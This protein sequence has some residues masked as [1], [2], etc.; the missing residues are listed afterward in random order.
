MHFAAIAGFLAAVFPMVATPGASLTLLTQRV[1][2]GGPRQ[3]LLVILGTATGLYVHMTLAAL[4]LSGLVMHSSQAFAAVRLAGAVYLVAL[5]IWTWRS[6][7]VRPAARQAL[8]SLPW[9]GHSTYV[10]ALLG[11]VLN[12]K[13]ASIYLTLIPQ[14]LDL[15]DPVFI[16]I[17]IL[18]TGHAL[19][20]TLWLL[21]WTA[22]IARAAH[23][24]R[25]PSFKAVLSRITG[26]VLIALG[27]RAAMR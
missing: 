10:Q 25:S 14:F 18:A 1:S 17:L 4:G 24:M 21:L 20:I 3:G 22:V 13:A 16:Q 15:H 11:N 8:T 6:A 12:P 23:A 7:T 2:D 26:T 27:L 9:A 19:L 5:G